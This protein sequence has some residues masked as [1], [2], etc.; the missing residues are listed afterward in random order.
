[1]KQNKMNKMLVELKQPTTRIQYL[2]FL[3]TP[4]GRWWQRLNLKKLKKAS[5]FNDGW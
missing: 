1:M 2:H 5:C 4:L 3:T